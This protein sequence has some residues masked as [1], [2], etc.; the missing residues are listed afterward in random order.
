MHDVQWGRS[1]LFV[2]ILFH[3]MARAE[4]VPHLGAQIVFDCR[5]SVKRGGQTS[6][7]LEALP[8]Y[9]NQTTFEICKSPS[10]GT[11]SGIT[12][13]DDHS[14]SVIYHH[15]GSEVSSSDEFTFRARSAGKAKSAQAKALID[16][17]APPSRL[18]FTPSVLDFGDV[19]LGGTNSKNLVL[20]NTGGSNLSARLALPSG[21]SIPAGDRID[22]REREKMTLAVAFTPTREGDVSARVTLLPDGLPGGLFLKG[23]GRPRFEVK[24]T[25][26]REFVI[27]N[28]SR[29]PLAIDCEVTAGWAMQPRLLLSPDG[30]QKIAINEDA[31]YGTNPVGAG[32]SKREGRV[33]ISDGLT[34]REITVSGD[35]RVIPVNAQQVSPRELGNIGMGEATV[36]SFR[37]L[38]RSATAKT[39][40][41]RASSPGG[42]AMSSPFEATLAG[43]ELKEIHYDWIPAR[44]GPTSLTIS[45]SE[46]NAPTQELLWKASAYCRAPE[47][48]PASSAR[49]IAESN[50]PSGSIASPSLPMERK[51]ARLPPVEG[52]RGRMETTWLGSQLPELTW[53][54]PLGAGKRILIQDLV[55]VSSTPGAK[56]TTNQSLLAAGFHM[57]EMSLTILNHR[58]DGRVR[59]VNL[60]GLSAGWHKL[61]VTLYG[62]AGDVPVAV[63]ILPFRVEYQ[64]WPRILG[65]LLM[66]LIGFLAMRMF[67]RIRKRGGGL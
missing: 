20:E 44:S 33:R 4:K 15:D 19:E 27:K 36:V 21:F 59:G 40:S 51:E 60:P 63:S 22:L 61:K 32:M 23:R 49:I 43:G 67:A 64:G 57:E 5:A 42:I 10:H 58:E 26:D 39:V 55:L 48:L 50:N 24:M 18:V 30:A 2:F 13:S 12:Y 52:L 3:C 29:E 54:S 66:L 65:I 46:R 56:F 16:V 7:T 34:T 45:F 37:L 38:N 53:V 8:N 35:D 9:G 47:C 1:W 14:A 31:R 17:I 28:T 6:I 25:G 11:L 41:W 62:G